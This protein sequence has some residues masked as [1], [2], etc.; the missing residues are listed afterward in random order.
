[1]EQYST[2]YSFFRTINLQNHVYDLQST[3]KGLLFLII[4]CKLQQF[5]VCEHN[6]ALKIFVKL[7]YTLKNH[8]I[9]CFM[10]RFCGKNVDNRS[11]LFLFMN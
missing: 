4:T 10:R 2:A 3:V 1:M 5:L 11:I 7:F 8:K 6:D 9:S